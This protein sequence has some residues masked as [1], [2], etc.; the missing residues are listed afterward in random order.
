MSNWRKAVI[1]ILF[2][3]MVLSLQSQDIVLATAAQYKQFMKSTT[4]LVKYDNPFSSFN[5]TMEI[6]MQKYWTITPY[7]IITSA[8]FEKKCTDNTASFIFFSEAV[9]T[10]NEALRFNILNIV[11][12]SK[13]ANI[14]NMPDLGSVPLSYA[15]EEDEFAEEDYL[16]KIGVVLKFIQYYIQI[17][18][19]K[20]DTDVKALVKMNQKCILD[21][22]I[23]F[24]ASEL[25]IEVNSP[26]K[27]AKY[28]SGKVKIVSQQ[29]IE[30]AI[31][32]GKSGVLILHKV[33]PGE[34]NSGKC[35]KFIVSASDGSPYFYSISDVSSRKPDAF[36]ADDFKS[37]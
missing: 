10:N 37:L 7:K 2:A 22:E 14:N 11:M 3:F 28:Y 1:G 25:D 19:T 23:W 18:V 20:P 12:G 29:E 13:S 30:T 15:I 27:I 32:N 8:E 36:T 6:A 16:Y 24:L 9:T 21:N 33:G 5:S 4:Y 35:L 31:S 34:S 17:N 26:E